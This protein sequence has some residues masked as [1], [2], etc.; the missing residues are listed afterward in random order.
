MVRPRKCR[1]F[2]KC[3]LPSAFKPRGCACGSSDVIVLGRDEIE[4]IRLVDFIGNEQQRAADEMEI[5]R[6][7]LQRTYKSARRKIAN[8][9]I[10]G[11]EIILEKEGGSNAK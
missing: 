10:N 8:A 9:I 2:C 3:S 1:K 11:K 6:A 7:T 5:S 4:A